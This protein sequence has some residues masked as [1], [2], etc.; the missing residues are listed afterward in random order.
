MKMLESFLDLRLEL[1]YRK[2]GGGAFYFFS[3][4]FEGQGRGLKREEGAHLI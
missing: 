3:S 1:W 2:W 4:T